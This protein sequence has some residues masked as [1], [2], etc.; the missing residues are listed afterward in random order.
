MGEIPLPSTGVHFNGFI[1]AV[2]CY[3]Q[4]LGFLKSDDKNNYNDDVYGD[5]INDECHN[6]NNDDEVEDDDNK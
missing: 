3:K 1:Y 5:D 2:G 6:D 4:F